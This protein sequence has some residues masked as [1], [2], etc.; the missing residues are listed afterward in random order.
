SP[1]GAVLPSCSAIAAHSSFRTNVTL[2]ATGSR[3]FCRTSRSAEVSKLAAGRLHVRGRGSGSPSSRR[4]CCGA[5]CAIER[6]QDVIDLAVL[7]QDPRFGGGGRALVRAF[8][9]GATALGR[10]PE[11]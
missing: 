8:L 10:S 7:G 1:T 9:D 11:L 3:D 4:I 6:A 5:S 2:F